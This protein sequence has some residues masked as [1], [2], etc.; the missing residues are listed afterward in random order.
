[1][2]IRQVY[3]AKVRGG[4]IERDAAQ[5]KIVRL[6]DTLG[7]T[8][9]G[10]SPARKSAALGWLLGAKASSA[11]KGLY[12]WGGVGRG[13]SMLMDMFFD[14]AQVAKK[15]RVH[16]HAFMAEVHAAIFR[17]RQA[18][19]KGTVK[20]EDPIEPVAEEI[21]SQA[22]LLCFDEF[23]ITDIADA[24]ILGRLFKIL[25]TR[26]VVVVATSN[27]EPVDLYGD[28]LNRAL[29]LPSID[30]I[31]EHM[32]VVCSMGGKV[33]KV[34]HVEGD[35]IKLTKHDSPD[36]EHHYIPTSIVASVDKVVHL[37][38]TG[39]EVKTMWTSA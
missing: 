2:P 29:F 11:P 23:T 25:F 38:K 13:K 8:L 10:Y 6:L 1:M 32:D 39:D 17:Y 35:R 19:R 34:D 14:G 26:G 3:E 5:Q 24:M 20:G 27:V 16:F 4:Q 37:S 30:L 36:A 7:D 28:G 9:E 21:A 22:T 31:Q 33:G 15:R 18:L 12:I